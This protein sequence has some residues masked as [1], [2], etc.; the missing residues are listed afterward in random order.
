V[1]EHATRC[2]RRRPPILRAA[3]NQ[4]PELWCPECGRTCPAPDTRPTSKE[5]ARA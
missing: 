1:I 4:Q 5:T 3:W 2:Q